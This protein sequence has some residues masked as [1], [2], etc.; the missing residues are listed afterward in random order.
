MIEKLMRKNA[1]IYIGALI[2]A[3]TV[4]TALADI[5]SR[6]DVQSFIDSMVK[7]QI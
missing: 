6:S 7:A 3:G 5:S 1:W 4:T 2:L